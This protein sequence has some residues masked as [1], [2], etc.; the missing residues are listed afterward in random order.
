MSAKWGEPT[1]AILNGNPYAESLDEYTDPRN[2]LEAVA[3]LALAYEQ[4][5]ANMIAYAVTL[6]QTGRGAQAESI[7][8][9]VSERLGLATAGDAA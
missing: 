6:W 2:S 1:A 5:T 8:A 3:T 7:D 4:Q 9:L